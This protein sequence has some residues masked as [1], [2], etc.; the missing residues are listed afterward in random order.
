MVRNEEDPFPTPGDIL[1]SPH[2]GKIEGKAEKQKGGKASGNNGDVGRPNSQ[3]I[4]YFRNNHDAYSLP[5]QGVSSAADAPP[6]IDFR[7][8]FEIPA[9]RSLIQ[10]INF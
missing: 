8:H 1:P 3:T 6:G 5:R 10:G 2:T 7:R 9:N 4:D